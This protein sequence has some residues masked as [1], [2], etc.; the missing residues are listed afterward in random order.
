[1]FSLNNNNGYWIYLKP[2]V[3]NPITVTTLPFIPNYTYNFNPKDNDGVMVTENNL[4]NSILTFQ[5]DGLENKPDDLTQNGTNN[6]YNNVFVII[7]GNEVPL[8]NNAGQFTV[9]I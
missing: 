4:V 5:I 8:V 6:S 2:A 3:V 7:A 1:M 9:N